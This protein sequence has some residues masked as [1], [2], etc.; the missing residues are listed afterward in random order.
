MA[1]GKRGLIT[2]IVCLKQVLDPEAPASAYKVDNEAKRIIQQGVPPVISTFDENALEAA[3]RVK[4]AHKAKITV[5]SLGRNLSK[6]VLRKSLAAGA[7]ELVLLEDDIFD[8]LDSCATASILAT[9]IRKIG[10]Y[11]IILTGMQAADWNAGIVGSGIA[12]ILAVPSV[13]TARKVELFDGRV[14]VERVLSDGYELI[15][16]PL[17]VLITVSNDLGELR[18]VAL[19]AIMAAQKKPL[20]TWSAEDLGV[21]PSQL[22]RTK[23]LRLFIPQKESR[24]EMVPGETGE[25]LGANLALKLRDEQVI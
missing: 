13:T 21:E 10:K 22:R 18:S 14:R 20:K 9:A 17:P 19:P 16:A 4:D 3:L 25:E 23:L 2:I 24:C 15:E 7:D 8:D 12:E 1:G 11:D 5:L 6:A